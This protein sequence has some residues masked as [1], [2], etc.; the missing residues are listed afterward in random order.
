M[1]AWLKIAGQDCEGDGKMCAWGR[2]ER[3][4]RRERRED[5]KMRRR[6]GSVECIL[7]LFINERD[8][9]T[10]DEILLGK[11]GAVSCF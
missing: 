7:F 2:R 9:T 3:R 6:E 8:S 11:G 1:R 10:N 5:M 4:M